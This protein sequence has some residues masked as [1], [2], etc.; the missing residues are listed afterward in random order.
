VRRRVSKC[1]EE[2]Q[3]IGYEIPETAELISAKIYVR[4]DRRKTRACKSCDGVVQLMC[5]KYELGLM[6]FDGTGIDVLA[7]DDP[8]GKRRGALWGAW[9]GAAPVRASRL[10]LDPVPR[11]PAARPP[12]AGS[13]KL[14]TEMAV[15]CS[16]HG[17]FRG[18]R[19]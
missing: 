1:V 5:D 18:R 12:W 14:G 9:P 2:R 10:Y 8:R 16:A 19:S 11:V 15:S 17:A 4:C 3:V 13:H 7:R 6:Y